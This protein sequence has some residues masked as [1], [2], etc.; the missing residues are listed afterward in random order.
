MQL[1][2][3]LVDILGSDGSAI[4]VAGQEVYLKYDDT[5]LLFGKF[6]PVMSDQH[7]HVELKPW[8]ELDETYADLEDY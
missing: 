2:K 5:I 7:E 6:Y 4:A 8:F 1:V 3:L